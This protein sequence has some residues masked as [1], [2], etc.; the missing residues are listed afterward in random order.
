MTAT[1]FEFGAGFGLTNQSD[2]VLM[3]LIINHSF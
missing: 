3:K 2:R 1:S